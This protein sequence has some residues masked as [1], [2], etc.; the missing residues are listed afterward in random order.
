MPNADGRELAIF[1]NS[2]YAFYR[3]IRTVIDLRAHSPLENLV[4][5]FLVYYP[6][7]REAFA[8][9]ASLSA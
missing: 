9:C 3:N 6:R 2:A 7:L 8:F 1:L 4:F 5:T